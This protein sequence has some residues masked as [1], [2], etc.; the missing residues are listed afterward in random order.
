MTILITA[1]VSIAATIIVLMALAGYVVRVLTEKGQYASAFW[2]EKDRM[3]K[4]R[5]NYLA[6]SQRIYR[7]IQH[8]ARTGEKTVKYIFD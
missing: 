7:G 3:W 1:L 2:S 4:V 8:D 5:G 6:I